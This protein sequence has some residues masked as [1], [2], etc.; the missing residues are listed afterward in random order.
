[1]TKT[2]RGGAF[3][4]VA[5]QHHSSG[6]A[7]RTPVDKSVQEPSLSTDRALEHG[8]D[9]LP[10]WLERLSRRSGLIWTIGIGPIVEMAALRWLPHR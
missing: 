5:E 8:G 7:I 3:A 6:G 4:P 2:P 1:M 9:H 10:T